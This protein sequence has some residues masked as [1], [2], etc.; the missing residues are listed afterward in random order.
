[1]S[2]RRN[3]NISIDLYCVR[4]LK[5]IVQYNIGQVT[6]PNILAHHDPFYKS[7]EKDLCVTF[8]NNM[9]DGRGLLYISDFTKFQKKIYIYHKSG[10]FAAN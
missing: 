1:M 7:F 5:L 6:A 4:T 8:R 3:K 2:L 10:M 9:V